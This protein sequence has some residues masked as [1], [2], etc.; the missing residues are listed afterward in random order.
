VATR[1]TRKRSRPRAVAAPARPAASVAPSAGEFDAIFDQAQ[2]GDATA[3]PALREWLSHPKVLDLVGNLARLA[4]SRHI[5]KCAGTNLVYREALPRKLDQLRAELGGPGQ[6]PVEQLLVERVVSCWLHLHVLENTYAQ[7]GPIAPDL[8]MYYQRS[9]YLAQKG[10]LA[11]IKTLATVR[12]LA[13][14]ALQVNIGREQV[15]VLSAGDG[16]AQSAPAAGGR[17]PRQ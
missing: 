5:D 6:S 7:A 16:K 3:L 15:N 14:P 17:R 1:P 10:Y 4:Q 8:G 2:H 11:A 9:I 12:R 13:V